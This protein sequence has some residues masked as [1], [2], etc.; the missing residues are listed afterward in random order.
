MISLKKASAKSL[1]NARVKRGNEASVIL[2]II[3]LVAGAIASFYQVTQLVGEPPFVVTLQT[4]YPYQGIGIV[5]FVAGVIFIG[6]GLNALPKVLSDHKGKTAAGV[7]TAVYEITAGKF[8]YDL[9]SV[10]SNNIVDGEV[11][12]GKLPNGPVFDATLWPWPSIRQTVTNGSMPQL[13]FTRRMDAVDYALKYL[14]GNPFLEGAVIA[15]PFVIYGGYELVK[16]HRARDFLRGIYLTADLRIRP[17]A[18]LTK[19]DALKEIISS[20]GLNPEEIL[21][22]KVLA[23]EKRIE[24]MEVLTT[25]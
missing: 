19:I 20:W 4:S 3:F 14:N 22:H 25:I 17:R 21:S 11:W 24:P 1:V 8:L 5:L 15:A 16:S 9:N 2:G 18:K 7:L 13:L 10:L 6:L 12:R 23:Q